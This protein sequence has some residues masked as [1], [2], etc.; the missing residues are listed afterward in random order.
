M[1]KYTIIK[2]RRKKFS[3]KERPQF[4]LSP[5]EHIKA[6]ANIIIDRILEESQNPN[7]ILSWK[8]K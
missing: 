2:G 7:S 3:I 8:I 4:K 5:E 6:F 1:N